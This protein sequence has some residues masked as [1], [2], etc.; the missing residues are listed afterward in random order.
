LDKKGEII[1]SPITVPEV[2]SL[3]VLAGFRPV[4]CDIAPGTW[5]MDPHKI[6]ALIT[7]KTVA[8]MT[9]H[10]YGNMNTVFE[11]RKICDQFGLYMIEDAAQAIGAWLDNQHAGTIGDFGILSFSY[12]KNVTSFFGGALVT[13]NNDIAIRVKSSVARNPTVDKVWLYRRV[14]DCLIKDIATVLPIFQLVFKL[15]QYGYRNRVPVIMN[16]VSQ[17]LSER[18]LQSIPAQY[19]CRISA[20]QAK[21]VK[22]KWPDVDADVDHRRTCAKAYHD[23]LSGL[24]TVITAAFP[25]DRS[26]TYLYFPIQVSD[27]YALQSYL[28]EHGCDVAVQHAPNCASLAAYREYSSECPH[29]QAAYEG[30]LMLPTY[31]GFPVEKAEHYANIIRQYFKP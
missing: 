7:D 20:G 5:N 26:H 29:A 27:K 17:R 11:V 4:F 19:A 28:V 16:Q 9:T 10:F 23:A 18:R 31:P 6:K 14:W 21:A 3:V 2:I 13:N 22:D 12:P 30:T 25:G 24:S 1:L 8:V 15:I